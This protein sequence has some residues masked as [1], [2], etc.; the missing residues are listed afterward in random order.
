[1]LELLPSISPYPHISLILI[2]YSQDGTAGEL[3]IFLVRN[4]QHLD[5]FDAGGGMDIKFRNVCLPP[6]SGRHSDAVTKSASSHE[7]TFG[8]SSR[9]T[10]QRGGLLGHFDSTARP[11]LDGRGRASGE[12]RTTPRSDYFNASML[13][14]MVTAPNLVPSLREI[15]RL[16]CEM[17]RP[18]S[19]S[20]SSIRIALGPTLKV[21]CHFASSPCM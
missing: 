6:E 16:T 13:I 11:R 17:L 3:S 18:P 19:C 8:A 14:P 1:M 2:P 4:L 5:P 10:E 15:V 9:Q 7:R 21:F 20:T 12:E